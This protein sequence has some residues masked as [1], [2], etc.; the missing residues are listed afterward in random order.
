MILTASDLATL[1]E[2]EVATLPKSDAATLTETSVTPQGQAAETYQ[3]SMA[4]NL[5][6]TTTETNCQKAHQPEGDHM[7]LTD[8]ETLKLIEHES[9]ALVVTEA[10]KQAET[11]D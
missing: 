4:V 10:L 2:S 11:V 1:T 9:S 3:A 6:V 8:R 5:T 7:D